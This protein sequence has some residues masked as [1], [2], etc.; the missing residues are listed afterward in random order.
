MKP[1]KILI[2]GGGAGGASAA[3]RARR[4][5]EE[6]Q[7]VIAG[8]VPVA[9]WHELDDQTY[10]A[11][12]LLDVRDEGERHAG[13]IP[14]SV[15]IPLAQLRSRIAELPRDRE[16]IVYCQ[17][18][19]R[20]YNACRILRQHGFRACNL[21]GGYRTWR[22]ASAPT[23]SRGVTSR[24]GG[25]PAKIAAPGRWEEK[26]CDDGRDKIVPGAAVSAAAR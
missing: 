24:Q 5:S 18:G 19:Q 8:D 22:M 16:I 17:T 2:V 6:A 20:S 7:N 11:G 13:S 26:E 1:E 14:G 15:P 9:Q 25:S 3:A 4:R 12:L 10:P 21:T 23:D